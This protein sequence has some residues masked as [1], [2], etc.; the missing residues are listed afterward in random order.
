MERA[1]F[2]AQR[3]FL[4]DVR[5]RT[6][7]DHHPGCLPALP[8]CQ[9]GGPAHPGAGRRVVA[10]FCGGPMM[11]FPAQTALKITEK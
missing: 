3:V 5:S 10:H 9:A 6:R 2:W 7:P 8:A 4:S 11:Y 1:G